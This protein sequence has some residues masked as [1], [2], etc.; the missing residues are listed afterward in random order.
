[1]LILL[2]STLQAERE[3]LV[4]PQRQVLILL[5]ILSYDYQLAERAKN[6]LRIGILFDPENAVSTRVAKDIQS[7]LRSLKKAKATVQNMSVRSIL[8]PF[9]GLG[10]LKK[11]VAAQK[12]NTIYFSPGLN[13]ALSSI[14]KFTRRTKLNTITGVRRYVLA[15]VAAGTVLDGNVPKILIHLQSSLDHGQSFSS[16]LLRIATLIKDG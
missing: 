14:L 8:L 1:M 5:K 2:P 6:T 11:Q 12:V 16:Q 10:A 7:A 4:P 15:G 3:I 13:G 9:Q